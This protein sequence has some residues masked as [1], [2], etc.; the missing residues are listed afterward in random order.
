MRKKQKGAEQPF[1]VIRAGQKGAAHKSFME[2]G[3]IALADPGLGNLSALERNRRA[4]YAA[5]KD[6]HPDVDRVAVS[7]IGGKFFRF[8]H[9]MQIGDY[10]LYP[11]ILDNDRSIYF[12]VVAGSYSYNRS[13]DRW[14]PHR[15]E[16]LWKCSIP[17]R[18]LS[19]NAKRELGAARTFFRL[20][21]H[22]HE[23]HELRAT[24]NPI[25]SSRTS[26]SPRMRDVFRP[27]RKSK[28]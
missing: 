25:Q 15:R 11:C 5:Y 21:K 24:A 16:V 12:G 3:V 22:A 13:V 8:I 14:F 2:G 17:K 28:R 6:R 23:I 20:I 27:K 26:N 4:F 7:G 10:V 9:E 18:R 1:W 19:E